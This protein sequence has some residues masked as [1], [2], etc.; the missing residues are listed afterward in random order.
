MFVVSIIDFI[1]DMIYNI[2][3]EVTKR[4]AASGAQ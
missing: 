1:N 3:Y 4:I 2:D